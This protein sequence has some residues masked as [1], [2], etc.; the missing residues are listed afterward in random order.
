MVT[1]FLMICLISP[2][3]CVLS[4]IRLIKRFD[5]LD[6]HFNAILKA[7]NSQDEHKED[8]TI[9]QMEEI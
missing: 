7:L 2:V 9:V 1:V 6:N 4:C 5:S 8:V 3:F